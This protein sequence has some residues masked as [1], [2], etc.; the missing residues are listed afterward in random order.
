M[1]SGQYW[2]KLL[3][4]GLAIP[5]ILPSSRLSTPLNSS[6]PPLCCRLP[7]CDD[8]SEKGVPLFDIHCERQ[9]YF[10]TEYCGGHPVTHS[11]CLLHDPD[12]RI[13]AEVGPKNH[14]TTCLRSLDSRRIHPPGGSRKG[15]SRIPAGINRPRKPAD[16]KVPNPESGAR[17]N[18][19]R[20]LRLPVYS[21]RQTD[22]GRSSTPQQSQSRLPS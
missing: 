3:R 18:T 1:G 16:R 2:N 9:K 10:Y 7:A 6:P 22:P 21:I 8:G 19:E 12:N 5:I 15:N 17:Q 4:R 20:V 11:M 13:N 14:R